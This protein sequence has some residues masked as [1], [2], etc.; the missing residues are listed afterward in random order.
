[1]SNISTGNHVDSLLERLWTRPRRNNSQTVNVE[2]LLER[3]WTTRRTNKCQTFRR[4]ATSNHC[5]KDLEHDEKQTNVKHFE[6][7]PRWITDRKTLNATKNKE[8]SNISKGSHDELLIERPWTR[9]R[10][11][12]GQ[13]VHLLKYRI[14]YAVLPFCR[15]LT[16]PTN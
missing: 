3:P 14:T 7:Q 6:G 5:S 10:T 2:S 13:K 15:P 11:N 16:I 4:A 9:R 12:N 1:M 8:K